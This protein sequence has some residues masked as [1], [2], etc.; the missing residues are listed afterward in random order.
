MQV[1]K[2]ASSR[3]CLQHW[4]CCTW[5]TVVNPAASKLHQREPLPV[6]I[7][8]LHTSHNATMVWCKTDKIA[9]HTH[10]CRLLPCVNSTANL[11]RHFGSLLLTTC[12]TNR[13]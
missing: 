10:I 4:Q 5:L 8:N 11:S 7:L 12:T 3:G 6:S 2:P 13:Q 9:S 1:A